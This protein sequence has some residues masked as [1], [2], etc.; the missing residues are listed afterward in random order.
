MRRAVALIVVL[1]GLVVVTP[2]VWASTYE[3]WTDGV[4]DA[5][6]GDDILALLS[7]SVFDRI[8][9]SDGHGI[10]VVVGVV[11]LADDTV[12]DLADPSTRSVR[13]PPTA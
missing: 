13:A 2:F 12:G 3:A 10:E 8:V 5:E 6:L 4:Y 9:L 1:I 11:V 7:L